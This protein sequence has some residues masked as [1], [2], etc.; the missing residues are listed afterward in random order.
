MMK[1]TLR[2]LS[3]T[4]LL[5]KHEISLDRLHIAE[6]VVLRLLLLL[7][8]AIS[9]SGGSGGKLGLRHSTIAAVGPGP[10]IL[11]MMLLLLE[12]SQFIIVAS[13][14]SV[15]GGLL[16]KIPSTT[17]SSGATAT[18]RGSRTHIILLELLN[19]QL[20]IP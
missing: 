7:K 6:P 1:K 2:H 11:M 15:H 8:D 4:L 16:A 18:T 20:L 19:Q 3:L 13:S 14:S 5:L 17:S 9:H 10:V 12:T